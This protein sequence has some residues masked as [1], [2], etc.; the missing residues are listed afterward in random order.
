SSTW[1][2]DGHLGNR[3]SVTRAAMT[4]RASQPAVPLVDLCRRLLNGSQADIDLRGERAVDRAFAGDLHPLYALFC[5][6]CASQFDF[7]FDSV[8]HTL[9]G[10]AVFAVLSVNPRVPKRNG[11]LF[12]GQ[13]I[14]ARVEADCHGGA[15]TKTRQ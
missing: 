15:N 6:Q 11:D 7:D 14:S 2:Q 5:S 9:L 1:G 3:G 8:H 12:K 10:F 4:R 13:V